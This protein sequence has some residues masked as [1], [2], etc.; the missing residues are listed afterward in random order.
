[1]MALEA[2]LSMLALLALLSSQSLQA[3]HVPRFYFCIKGGQVG[4]TVG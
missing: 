4:E 1:M 3:I 2:L